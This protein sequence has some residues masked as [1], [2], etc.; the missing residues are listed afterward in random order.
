[1][2]IASSTGSWELLSH[3]VD[4]GRQLVLIA[5]IHVTFHG[6]IND[7]PVVSPCKIHCLADSRLA[8]QDTLAC[9]RYLMTAGGGGGNDDPNVWPVLS[10]TLKIQ[11]PPGVIG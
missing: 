11:G 2:C 6:F 1:M 10:L 4:G 8:H 9:S 3:L 7:R 5:I